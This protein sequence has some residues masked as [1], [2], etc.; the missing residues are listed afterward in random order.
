[1]YKLFSKTAFPD[2]MCKTLNNNILT[3][4]CTY[5]I[6]MTY[7]FKLILV[8]LVLVIIDFLYLLFILVNYFV[9]SYVLIC[10]VFL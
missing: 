6:S 10:T 7:L 5:Y 3:V 2:V 1:M 8:V 9:N 4:F